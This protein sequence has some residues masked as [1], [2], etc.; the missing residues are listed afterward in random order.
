MAFVLITDTEG[1]ELLIHTGQ[2]CAPSPWR[3]VWEK[4]DASQTD[5]TTGPS[6]VPGGAKSLISHPERR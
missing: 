6:R 4:F 5:G 3:R 2:L 1:R